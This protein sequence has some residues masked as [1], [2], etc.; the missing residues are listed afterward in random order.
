VT[1]YGLMQRSSPYAHPHDVA[2]GLTLAAVKQGVRRDAKGDTVL[3]QINP[4]EAAMLI[5][6][7]GSGRRDTQTGIIHFDPVGGSNAGGAGHGGDSGNMGGKG[8]GGGNASSGGTGQIGGGGGFGPGHAMG[9]S[10]GNSTYSG[11]HASGPGFGSGP[12]GS[13]SGGYGQYGSNGGYNG[14]INLNLGK[15]LDGLALGM[16][17]GAGMALSG[18][19]TAFGP[20]WGPSLN[21]GGTTNGYQISGDKTGTYSL[22]GSGAPGHINGPGQNGGGQGGWAGQPGSP[23]G[24][25]TPAGAPGGTLPGG[26]PLPAGGLPPISPP[27]TFQP[28]Q[29]NPY[30]PWRQFMAYQNPADLGALPFALP[31]Q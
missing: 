28:P 5:A 30:M 11:T 26:A 12:T 6:A 23:G 19:N 17:P 31:G 13:P 10:A 15:T 29:Q 20:T 16:I 24:T 22:G 25:G 3:A 9:G 1:P 8:G 18:L 14:G 27:Q 4:H 7:G 21:I 2:R